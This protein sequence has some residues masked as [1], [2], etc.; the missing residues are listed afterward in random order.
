V[1]A[2]KPACDWL[3]VGRSCVTLVVVLSAHRM[4]GPLVFGELLPG[5][6]LVR[7]FVIWTEE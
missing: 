4:W 7:R 5:V 1:G 6:L 2:A 3:W